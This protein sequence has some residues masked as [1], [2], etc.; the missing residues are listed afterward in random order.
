[1]KR[2]TAMIM[3]LMLMLSVMVAC[4]PKAE[5]ESIQAAQPVQ[6]E[7]TVEAELNVGK[8]TVNPMTHF[9]GLNAML[10]GV[11]DIRMSDVPI[12]AT[13]ISYDTITGGEVSPIAQIQFTLNGNKYTYRA[14]ACANE[15][16]ANARDIAGVY[17]A[18]GEPESHT[19]DS[20]ENGDGSYRL[21]WV[22]GSTKGLA[23]W[24]YAPTGCQYSL[25]T[26]TGCGE[27]QQIEEVVD[28]LM[29]IDGYT[30]AIREIVQQA[31]KTDTVTGVVVA[32]GSNQIVINLSNGNTLTFLMSRLQS[33]QAQVGDTVEIQYTG[34]IVNAPEAQRITIK[35]AAKQT[36]A[37]DVVQIDGTGIYVK[38]TT[39]NIYG[40]TQT[41]QTKITGKATTV[42]LDDTVQITYAGSLLNLPSA[43]VVEILKLAPAPQPD[44][45][46]KTPKDKTLDGWVTEIRTK[47]FTIVTNNGRYWT[48]KKDGSTIV[49]GSYTFQEWANVRVLYDGYASNKPL[50]REITVLA[51]PDPTPP[52]PQPVVYHNV[53]GWITLH[54]GNALS[55][56]TEHGR[57]YS[58]LLGA[59]NISGDP[60]S[61]NYAY[62]T[63][64]DANGAPVVTDITFETRLLQRD[65][66]DTE[67]D[68]D[69][70]PYI[71][72]Y[73]LDDEFDLK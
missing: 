28:E 7:Q 49:D 23:T 30:T 62:V 45:G 70:E 13:E 61:A 50:A 71:E 43:L 15:E 17:E 73:D 4:Q 6:V 18:F 10:A 26:E 56:Q 36:V 37:G 58:F 29:N 69:T 72:L 8:D 47:T 55:I 14:A 25:Y 2:L 24:F 51:P 67:T 20:N 65:K 32:V 39:G 60:D 35:T 46:K 3:M 44:P 52:T 9:E 38:T 63:Y 40:F 57:Q 68:V 19:A 34:D 53:E 64:Y 31:Q 33:T 66:P 59:P 1:M 27:D 41:K 54:A 11:P 42:K 48:F 5:A 21:V 12:G 22:P 16:T